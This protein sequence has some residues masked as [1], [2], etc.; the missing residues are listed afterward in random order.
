MRAVALFMLLFLPLTARAEVLDKIGAVVNT[1][2]ITCYEIQQDALSLKRQLLAQ[3]GTPPSLEQ[4]MQRAMD[5]RIMAALQEQEAAKLEIKVD[6]EELD[7]TIANIEEQNHLLPGQLKLALAQQGMDYDTYRE[8]LR[9]QILSSKLI[10]IAVRSKVQISEE[11]MRE[12]YRKYMASMHPVREVR[13]A[14][15]LLALPAEPAPEQV[16]EVRAKAKRIHRQLLQG[17]DFAQLA[18]LHSDGPEAEKGGVMGWFLPGGIASRFAAALE[19]PVGGISNPIRSP[20]GFHILTVLEERMHEPEK[21]GEAYDEVH[22]RHILLQIPKS[23]DAATRAKIMHRARTIAR[24]MADA[25]DEEFATRAREVSQ[26]PSASRG[27]DLGWFRRGAMVKA[28]EDAAFSL[29]PGQTSGVVES[30]FG[31]HIIRVIE[32][33]HVDPNSFEAR[34]DQI[35][36]ILIN[37]EMQEQLPRWLA[38][39]K[40]RAEI[41]RHDCSDVALADNAEPAAT[42]LPKETP[43]QAVER[44]RAAWSSRDIESYLTAYSAHF[45]PGPRFRSREE[46]KAYK[47]RVIGNKRFIRVTLA[48]LKTEMLD[49]THAR[50]HFTQRFESDRFSSRDAKT[51]ELEKNGDHWLITRETSQP[52]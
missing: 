1:K 28:F 4:L 11:A 22:A 24:N 31:L 30:P 44:W 52:L 25:S 32:R 29:K 34:Q 10:N 48:D 27:G 21:Q 20:A 15:I 23:A 50:V 7:K 38:G 16:A 36:Q 5:N 19:L 35:Q 46:W 2:A 17:G 41:E 8:N 39:L 47:Q 40:A 33:R 3:G 6:D 43:E 9:R 13:L 42:P 26:G 12:Y 45:D 18:R 49:A 37:A 14:Q 51:L